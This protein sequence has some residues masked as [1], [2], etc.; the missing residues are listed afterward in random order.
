M[1]NSTA[2]PTRA[3]TTTSGTIFDVTPQGSL[4][5]LSSFCCQTIYAAGDEPSGLTETA[6]GVLYGTTALR[7]LDQCQLDPTQT[8]G[9]GTIFQ[10][11][12]GR[13]LTTLYNFSG[14]DG[15][16]PGGLVQGTDGNLYGTTSIGG[17]QL[18][19]IY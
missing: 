14:P 17:L 6:G 11:G 13:Q 15:P 4:T 7:G 8:G 1:G 19:A 16:V 3:A 12:P 18:A 10:V 9:C 2:P 5:T